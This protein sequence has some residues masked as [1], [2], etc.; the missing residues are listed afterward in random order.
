M[1]DTSLGSSSIML[2]LQIIMDH[3]IHWDI[4]K[5]PSS[6]ASTEYIA[7]LRPTQSPHEHS[8]GYPFSPIDQSRMWY[9]ML[10]L[11]Y[12]SSRVGTRN[13]LLCPVCA[14]NI[15]CLIGSILRHFLCFWACFLLPASLY[16]KGIIG[17]RSISIH[18]ILPTISWPCY[19]SDIIEYRYW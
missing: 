13:W 1:I 9:L 12:G 15:P 16:R 8:P 14:V 11:W 6:D 10:S 17:P 4:A 3:R 19:T 2:F 7:C 5:V 18:T